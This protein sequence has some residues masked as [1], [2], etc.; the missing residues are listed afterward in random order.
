MLKEAF[1]RASLLPKEEQERIAKV[2]FSAMEAGAYQEDSDASA[3]E[4][5][6]PS[7]PAT[8]QTDVV[9]EQGNPALFK[10]LRVLCRVIL[11][12]IDFGILQFMRTRAGERTIRPTKR[13]SY[14]VGTKRILFERQNHRCVI[15]G[16]RRTLKNLQV[17]HVIP[18]VRGGPDN[19][20]NF[21]LLCPAC[22]QRKGI[23]TNQEFYERYKRVVSR[24]MLR[25]IPLP[26]PEE[27]AQKVLQDETRRT[28]TH[29]SIQEFQRTKYIS[30]GTKIKSGSLATG[31]V[32]GGGWFVAWPLTFPGGADLIANIAFFGGIIVGVSVCVGI[33]WR[34]KYT[35]MYEQ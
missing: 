17:D 27:V 2:M 21:Q 11:A 16:K 20:S 3:T 24:N 22:N 25:S 26:P 9:G 23:H 33:I 28:A 30:S 5:N 8:I 6:T 7:Y 1:E 4:A 31:A 34:A 15:C 12:V 35:G 14:P 13:R 19:I 18:V 29:A 32:T 10:V